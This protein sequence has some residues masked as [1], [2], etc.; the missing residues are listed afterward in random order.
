MKKIIKILAVSSLILGLFGCTTRKTQV[1]YTV[2]PVG[3]I[4]NYLA[5]DQLQLVSI[6]DGTIVQRANLLENYQTI[7]TESEILFHIGS[8]EPYLT[9]HSSSVSETNVATNDLS[10]MNAIYKFQRYTPIIVDGGV[11]FVESTYY[12][13]EVFDTID[14]DER[15]LYL[16]VDPIA[17]LSM[18]KDIRDWLVNTYPESKGVFEER[19]IALER[20]LVQLDAEFQNLA[21]SLVSSNT[22]IKIVT[23]TPTYGSWQKTYG[24]QLYP[25]VL[26]KYGVLPTE[27]QYEIIKNRITEDGVQYIAYEENL[28]VDMEELFNRLSTELNL[29][30]INLNDLSNLS[31]GQI[32]ENKDYLSLM[33]ENLAA[34]NAIVAA[35]IPAE[36]ETPD[37]TG[38]SSTGENGSTGTSTGTGGATATPTTTPAGDYEGEE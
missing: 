9:S 1:A 24:I 28:P 13:G 14:I 22:S 7:L 25:V 31:D 34:L 16:W 18:A 33:Y 20:E 30:V 3:Y 8:L 12:R 2:Y 23:M 27:A 10:S 5:G 29:T 32:A 6:Q 19:F 11:T 17:M 4:L 36:T 37:G 15:D 35:N 26:S 38:D 21:N